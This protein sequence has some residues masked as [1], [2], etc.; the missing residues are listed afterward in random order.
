VPTQAFLL[1]D[2]KPLAIA[3]TDSGVVVTLPRNAPSSIASVVT[4]VGGSQGRR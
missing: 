4:L 2:H 3:A 1:A